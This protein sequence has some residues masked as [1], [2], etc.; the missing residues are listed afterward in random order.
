MSSMP[1]SASTRAFS[2][3]SANGSFVAAEPAADAFGALVD[4]LH[5]L[6]AELGAS[7]ATAGSPITPA[8]AVCTSMTPIRSSIGSVLMTAASRPLTSGPRIFFACSGRADGAEEPVGGV[9]VGDLP[10]HERIDR[11]RLVD[12][13]GDRGRG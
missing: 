1:Y 9:G 11:E 4:Q 2:V 3:S 12:G 13:A 5:V 8:A 10:G 7:R 6:G